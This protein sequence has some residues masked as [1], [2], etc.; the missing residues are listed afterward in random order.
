MK[1]SMDII[2]D[3][4]KETILK[5]E[6]VRVNRITNKHYYTFGN[7]FTD[8]TIEK[9]ENN[10]YYVYYGDDIEEVHGKKRTY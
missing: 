2:K 1:I 9:I 6:G 3:I 5:Y 10:N 8:I 7:L 4:I